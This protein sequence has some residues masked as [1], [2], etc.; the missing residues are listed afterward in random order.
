MGRVFFF[1]ERNVF[2]LGRVVFVEVIVVGC[3]VYF[4][5]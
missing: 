1:C 5:F 3:G 4:F 2:F